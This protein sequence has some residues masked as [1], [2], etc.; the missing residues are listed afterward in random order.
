MK[1]LTISCTAQPLEARFAHVLFRKPNRCSQG[2]PRP[3]T[4]MNKVVA[5]VLPSPEPPISSNCQVT[6]EGNTV[7]L[8]DPTVRPNK[9]TQ[10][11]TFDDIVYDH[12]SLVDHVPATGPFRI[13]T[14]FGDRTR[15]PT[16]TICEI[17]TAISMKRFPGNG[18][19]L[20][21]SLGLL[22]D[23]SVETFHSLTDEKTGELVDTY[24]VAELIDVIE[25]GLRK[26]GR[27]KEAVLVLHIGATDFFEWV[28][29][30]KADT[31]CPVPSPFGLITS[32][33]LIFA[34]RSPAHVTPETSQST[35]FK[36]VSDSFAGVP[37]IWAMNIGTDVVFQ[38]NAAMLNTAG[39]LMGHC[40]DHVTVEH[41]SGV[42]VSPADPGS[43]GAAETVSENAAVATDQAVAATEAA[44]ALATPVSPAFDE[45]SK[46]SEGSQTSS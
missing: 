43:D 44:D 26:L 23:C 18:Q 46:G 28:L 7:V 16:K 21:V 40:H 19:A 36:L 9:F 39:Q 1:D 20:P 3:F 10:R 38:S 25:C 5:V 2:L 22:D 34:L 24:D 42:D 29:V 15:I 6:V 35:V 30:P 33:R 37:T 13:V 11:G 12:R 17:A 14:L 4:R 41:V 32:H 27:M 45:V 31:Y 8:T